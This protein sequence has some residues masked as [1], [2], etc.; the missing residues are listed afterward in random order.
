MD[1]LRIATEDGVSLEAEVRMPDGRPVGAAV[2]CHAHPLMGGSKDHPLLWSIRIALA[3][4]GFAVLSFNFRGTMGSGGI[5]GGGVAEVRDARAA[6]G[7]A[8]SRAPGPAFVCG[9]SF[10]ASVAMREAVDDDRVGALAV[11]G[12]PVSA[13][14]V[15]LPPLPGAGRLAAFATPVLLLTGEDD[16]Y[17]RPEDLRAFAGR[18]P[19]ARV[20]VVEGTD[21][22][23]ARRER[24]AAELVGGFALERLS[25]DRTSAA[26][27]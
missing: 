2:I 22:F 1:P 12:L 11:I 16:P 19:D 24:D 20:E 13:D 27:S 6:I 25:P 17:C 3:R 15:V 8:V 9:W 7:A 5:H 14:A 23:L 21:H 4:R 18:L 26:G 10:G